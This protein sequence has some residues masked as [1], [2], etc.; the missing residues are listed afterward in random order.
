MESLQIPEVRG[1]NRVIGKILLSAYLLLNEEKMKRTKK[2]PGM[3]ILEIFLFYYLL[4]RKC[5]LIASFQVVK[6]IRK[7]INCFS[8]NLKDADAGELISF[9][10]TDSQ[11]K[12]KTKISFSVVAS[13][14]I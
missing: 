6:V 5:F 12:N 13:V 1:S 10:L 11:C 8:L 2:K 3:G 9:H 7:E 4:R 14:T